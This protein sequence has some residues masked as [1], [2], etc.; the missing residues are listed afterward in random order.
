[1][2]ISTLTR[3]AGLARRLAPIQ[4]SKT[5]KNLSLP[6]RKKAVDLLPA[7]RKRA[8]IIA[9]GEALWGSRWQT[10]M[11][12][13][14]SVH[15]DTVNAWKRG[16]KAPRDAVFDKLRALVVERR[17]E[18]ASVLSQLE[19]SS[20]PRKETMF[21]SLI[22]AFIGPR[23]ASA[24]SSVDL[25]YVS[26]HTLAKLQQGEGPAILFG[27]IADDRGAPLLNLP[28]GGNVVTVAPARS[29]VTSMFIAHLLAP[30]Q[31]AAKRRAG[32]YPSIVLDK[33]GEMVNAT[34]ARRE[35]LGR[36]VIE[37]PLSEAVMRVN[38][39]TALVRD[40]EDL[41]ADAFDL[42]G[43]LLAGPPCSV[44]EAAAV[45]R[46]RG[47][48][49]E[50]VA[51]HYR[52]D[53]PR[54]LGHLAHL[55]SNTI[56]ILQ[57]GNPA[58]AASAASEGRHLKA[59]AEAF[60][61]DREAFD[62]IAKALFKRLS[63]IPA[64]HG[65]AGPM[66]V[67]P[68]GELADVFDDRA[69]LFITYEMRELNP[70]E[71][72]R[73]WLKL[74]IAGA[75]LLAARR[76][77]SKPVQFIV[78]E[79][80]ALGRIDVVRDHTRLAYSSGLQFWL[81]F[82]S[83]RGLEAAYGAASLDILANA[84]A[85]TFFNLTQA[86][87]REI[88]LLSGMMGKHLRI[89]ETSGMLKESLHMTMKEIQSLGRNEVVVVTRG[90]PQLRGY[91]A[92]F[93]HDDVFSS[94]PVG[95]LPAWLA[96]RHTGGQRGKAAGLQSALAGRFFALA[97]GLATL[98]ATVFSAPQASAGS[99]VESTCPS[100]GSCGTLMVVEPRTGPG[101]THTPPLSGT[102]GIELE[103]IGPCHDTAGRGQSPPILSG[104]SLKIIGS[105]GGMLVTPGSSGDAS[106][107]DLPFLIR[108][109]EGVDSGLAI[110][111]DSDAVIV[112]VPGPVD[113]GERS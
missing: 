111:P 70:R 19:Q 102:D 77:S 64:C 110:A 58:T 9:A 52:I 69:D 18:L 27:K 71:P 55:V 91:L 73:Y 82:N 41:E 28:L 24:P 99:L 46:A 36:K 44:E 4:L 48:L 109:P 68:A 84:A 21:S 98:A 85:F 56:E 100:D 33:R 108:P 50:L 43:L 42:A 14:V 59:F 105:T 112:V 22:A 35:Q 15:E 25:P 67:Q 87:R 39:L 96:V 90:V 54:T 57:E 23:Q 89:D 86:D 49:A 8:L 7:E 53:V 12:R 45:A 11:A 51:L 78:D 103:A 17:I 74:L 79:A 106:E 40:D 63:W 26:H 29:G 37:V 38:L 13:A 6:A 61:Q 94:L 16:T 81:R 31:V 1:M 10:D 80:G 20:R 60:T 65:T 76:R 47:I 34:R 30:G 72:Y 5:G 97:F 75:T 92:D 83:F 95:E 62:S 101:L 88:A 113:Q 2:R 93:L 104:G 107:A 3:L 32:G 66:A